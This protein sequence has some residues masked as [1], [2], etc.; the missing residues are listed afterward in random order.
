MEAGDSCSSKDRRA[1]ER[2]GS[3]GLTNGR[4]ISYCSVDDAV[5]D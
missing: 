4:T 1:V 2:G 3:T 5:A